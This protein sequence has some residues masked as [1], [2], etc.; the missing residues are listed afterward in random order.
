MGKGVKNKT[1]GLRQQ[2]NNGAWGLKRVALIL[3]HREENTVSGVTKICK[4]VTHSW[5][6]L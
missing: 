1:Y 4:D 2:Y 3:K 6:P 5:K